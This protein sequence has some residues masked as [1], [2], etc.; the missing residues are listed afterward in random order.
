MARGRS[1]RRTD[2]AWANFGDNVLAHDL[3]TGSASLLGGTGLTTGTTTTITRMRGTVAAVLDTGGV[4]E[5][6]LVLCGITLL[7][8]D[9][10]TAGNAPELHKDANDEGSWIWQGQIWLHS[11]AEAAVVDPN[12]SNSIEVDS[13]AMRKWRTGMFLGLV[14][15]T[16]AAL[17]TDQAGTVDFVWY[18]HVLT[19]Q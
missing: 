9:M 19:G 8:E 16:P 14:V 7:P 13:K 1:G 4:D 5:G 11:G 15:Q 17:W 6:G 18:V 10:A 12:L 2:Y 3:G